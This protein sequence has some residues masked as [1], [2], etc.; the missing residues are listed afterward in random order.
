MN[1]I[2]LFPTAVGIVDLEPALTQQEINFVKIQPVL[3]NTGNFSSKNKYL[4]DLPELSALRF[5]LQ[6]LVQQYFD[7]I[8]APRY[9]N[10]IRITQSWANFNGNSQYHHLHAHP[11]SFLSA[12]LYMECPADTAKIYFHKSGY[13]QLSVEAACT[14]EFN[15]QSHAM[16]ALAN[17]LLIFPS[18]LSHHV[19]QQQSSLPR[20]SLSFNTFVTGILGDYQGATELKL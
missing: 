18:H 2:S 17:R 1:I 10:Y 15:A 3:E 20:I 9:C 16:D 12:V 5:R 8:Q 13:Q 11:N 6:Q 7:T 19:E 14:N 4:L